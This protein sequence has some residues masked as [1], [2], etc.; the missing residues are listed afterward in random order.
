MDVD[1]EDESDAPLPDVRVK[2]T[3]RE[4]YE[5]N[6]ETVLF[7]SFVNMHSYCSLCSLMTDDSH[8]TCNF[9]VFEVMSEHKE[10]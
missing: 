8:R 3:T 2:L 7:S 9:P 1:D 4:F 10:Q 6:K 5:Q